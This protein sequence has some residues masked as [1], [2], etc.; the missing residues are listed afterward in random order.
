MGPFCIGGQMNPARGKVYLLGFGGKT[1][2]RTGSG[3][4]GTTN[5]LTQEHHFHVLWT[6]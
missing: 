4:T 1:A 3:D 5:V 6:V 2:A